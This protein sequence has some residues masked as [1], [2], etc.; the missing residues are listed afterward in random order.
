MN[1]SKTIIL[2]LLFAGVVEQSAVG[3][4]ENTVVMQLPDVDP[5]PVAMARAVS[6]A[7]AQMREN[8]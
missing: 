7:V 8:R 5:Y 3:T 1:T 4:G 6:N 2:G